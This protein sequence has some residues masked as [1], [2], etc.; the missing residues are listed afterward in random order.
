LVSP[1]ASLGRRRRVVSLATSSERPE[2]PPKKTFFPYGVASFAGIREYECFFVDKT[3]AIIQL[4]DEGESVICLRPPRWGKSLTVNILA[5]YLDKNTSDEEFEKLFRGLAIF[6]EDKRGAL[7]GRFYVM[8]FDLTIEVGDGGVEGIRQRL[9]NE[10]NIRVK[11]FALRY[12]LNGVDFYPDDGLA[13]LKS[14]AMALKRADPDAELFVLVDEYDRFANELMVLPD[15]SLYDGVVAAGESDVPGKD[16]GPLRGFLTTIKSLSGILTT[17]S[18]V[19]GLTPI[20]L[21]DASSANIFDTITFEESAA[22]VFGFTDVDVKEGLSKL[23]HLGDDERR[24]AF[25]FVTEFF[26]GHLYYP[27][28]DETPELDNPQLS[29]NFFQ[30]L[31][32]NE[33]PQLLRD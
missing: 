13:S 29:M 28:D 6:P 22:G 33:G 3:E 14:A 17:R 2:A 10:I 19:T 27:T 1:I 24:M 7:C 5:S 23:E 18:F 9:F 31:C 25:D 15:S 20:S 12:N 26:K 32:T 11:D 16:A 8:K 21:A 4:L 30:M